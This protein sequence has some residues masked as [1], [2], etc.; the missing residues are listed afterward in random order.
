[1]FIWIMSLPSGQFT[2]GKAGK[3]ISRYGIKVS[4]LLPFAPGFITARSKSVIPYW[5][6]KSDFP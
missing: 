6:N 2:T 3:P 4:Q 1:M 5:L